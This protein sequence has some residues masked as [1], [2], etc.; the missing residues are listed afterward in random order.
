[1]TLFYRMK[2]YSAKAAYFKLVGV[3]YSKQ[4]SYFRKGSAPKERCPR[5]SVGASTAEIGASQADSAT[6][7]RLTRRNP[8]RPARVIDSCHSSPLGCSRHPTATDRLIE[9]QYR[10]KATQPRIYQAVLGV[11][12]GLLSRAGEIL[13]SRAG[14]IRSTVPSRNR[15]SPTSKARCDVATT[16]RV[17]PRLRLRR[18]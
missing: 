3:L 11:E 5:I 6:W 17:Q 1:M 18:Q 4:Q 2:S 14:E 16:G 9:A 15:V 10:L 12:Q 13:L 7:A 8:I